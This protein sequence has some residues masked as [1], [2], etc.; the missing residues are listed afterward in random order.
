MA[1]IVLLLI[2]SSFLFPPFAFLYLI[3][4]HDARIQRR[5]LAAMWGFAGV[6]FWLCFFMT[7]LGSEIIWRVS[8]ETLFKIHAARREWRLRHERDE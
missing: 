1:M 2:I 4:F 8:P 7:N 5:V 3:Q 6:L